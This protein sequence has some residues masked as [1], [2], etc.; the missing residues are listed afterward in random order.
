MTEQVP[1]PASAPR[2]GRLS[3]SS[4]SPSRRESKRDL[5]ESSGAGNAV[6]DTLDDSAALGLVPE[7]WFRGVEACRGRVEA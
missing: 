5:L 3:L 1:R 2:V 6:A 7:P 4:E